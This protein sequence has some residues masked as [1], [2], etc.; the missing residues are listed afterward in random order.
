MRLI[1]V[2]FLCLLACGLVGQRRAVSIFTTATLISNTQFG[3]ARALGDDEISI[4][5]THGMATVGANHRWFG[6]SRF[7]LETGLHYGW[8][9]LITS[10]RNPGDDNF[11]ESRVSVHSLA[12]PFRVFWGKPRSRVTDRTLGGGFYVGGILQAN[13]NHTPHDGMAALQWAVH[14]TLQPRLIPHAVIGARS[15]GRLLNFSFE[16]GLPVRRSDPRVRYG[17]VTYGFP[18]REIHYSIGVGHTIK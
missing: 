14:Q 5:H 1:S 8:R 9:Q 10:V 17:G 16:V 13:I 4:S 7:N 3:E 6:R 11:R 18:F 2:L 12:V 15:N